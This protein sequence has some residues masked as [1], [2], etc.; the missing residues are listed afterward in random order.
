MKTTRPKRVCSPSYAV[1]KARK[2]K[3]LNQWELEE[4]AKDAKYSY[5]Y[6]EKVLKGRFPEGEASIA[7][8]PDLAYAYAKHIIK[9]RFPEAEETFFK[10]NANWGSRDFIDNY[11]IDIVQEPNSKVEKFI[12]KRN[13]LADMCN[14]AVKCL[15]NR[16]LAAEKKLLEEVDQAIEYHEALFE[17]R[18]PE[19]E[20]VILSKKKDHFMDNPSK[21]FA[22]YLEKVGP[23]VEIEQKLEDCKR[24]SM[25]FA[26]AVKAARGKLPHALHQKMLMFS[27]DPKK[28]KVVKNY[29]SFLERAEQRAKRFISQ[30][31]ADS[32]REFLAQFST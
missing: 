12:L 32:R 6:A 7:K 1:V 27:F 29:L 20:D 11:F 15:K 24:A 2:G 17:G 9:G 22:T 8:D 19:L 25:L 4:L 31:D 13:D 21:D 3:T 16:W 5:I 18:W 26:Y 28:Q 30:L 10:F 14:Y 23:S